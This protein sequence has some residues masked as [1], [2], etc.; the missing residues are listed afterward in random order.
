MSWAAQYIGTPWE[1]GA[2]GPRAYDCLG[3]F[4]MVQRVHFGVD[5]PPVMTPACADASAMDALVGLIGGRGEVDRWPAV[6]QPRHGDAVLVHRPLHI[7]VWLDADGGGV[8]HCVEGIGVIFTADAAWRT[9]G[10]GRREYF[11]RE[12]A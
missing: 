5:L 9:S 4:R 12:A 1:I 8:L 2:Q 10:F 7:G 11:R 3:F 6:Q